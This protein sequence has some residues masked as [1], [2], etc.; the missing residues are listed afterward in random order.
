MNGVTFGTKH[1]YGSWGLILSK[2]EISYPEPQT[3]SVSVPGRDGDLDLTEALGAGVVRYK[4]RTLKFT[5]TVPNAR[6]GW[7]KQSEIASYLHGQKLK[8]ILD[9]EKEFYWY[10]RC[11]VDSYTPNKGICTV[12]IKCDVEPYKMQVSDG[13]RYWL[14]D[15]FSFKDS[16]IPQNKITLTSG[17]ETKVNLANLKKQVSP[18][19]TTTTHDVTVT[20]NG[21]T[22]SLDYGT[23]TLYNILLQ[24][25]DNFLTFKGTGTVTISYKGGML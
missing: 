15:P 22:Y 13:S 19:F 8:I 24:E 6:W 7:K 20:F 10:G 17:K 5:F 14:W 25:G 1:S 4:N 21:T 23:S 9:E 18:T 3:E 2:K 16:I 12:V 11:M